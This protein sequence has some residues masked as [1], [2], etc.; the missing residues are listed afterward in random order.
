MVNIGEGKLG[1]AA[2][3]GL[4]DGRAVSLMDSRDGGKVP[5]YRFGDLFG[6]LPSMRQGKDGIDFISGEGF[7]DNGG[8]VQVVVVLYLVDKLC[9]YMNMVM[10][11]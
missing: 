1:M 4:G 7:H 9:L 2:T 5:A 8:C 10:W 3:N 6:R 11:F